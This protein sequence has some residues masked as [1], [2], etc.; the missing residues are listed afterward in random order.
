M[1]LLVYPVRK[2]NMLN[3]YDGCLDKH[4]LGGNRNWKIRKE[5]EK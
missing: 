1:L 3:M 4:A 5:E 2:K